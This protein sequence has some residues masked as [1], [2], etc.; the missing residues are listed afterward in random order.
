M[1]CGKALRLDSTV[2]LQVDD[3]V[4]RVDNMTMAWGLKPVRRSSTTAWWSCQPDAAS[5]AGR[6][7]VLKEAAARTSPVR[8]STAR[9]A[10]SCTGL[11]HLQ[12]DTPERGDLVAA[13]PEPG[14]RPVQPGDAR[15]PAHR[16][17]R[18]TDRMRAAPSCGMGSAETCGSAN[19]DL[20]TETHATAYSQRRCA[21]RRL[22]TS[23][24][25]RA[26]PKTAANPARN[27]SPCI[28]AGP[29]A[30]W[31]YLP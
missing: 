3:P 24:C 1:P 18:P 22:P 29:I 21:A 13:G 6:R 7:Q 28:A 16:S 9:K 19:K 4:K 25:K 31:P 23:A 15:P 11:K 26:W 17:T 27:P 5:A 2:M 8:S 14:S 10:T 30:D 12:G 20:T